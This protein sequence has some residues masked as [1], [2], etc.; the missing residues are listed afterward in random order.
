MEKGELV[1]C[2]TNVLIE[3]YKGNTN[4]ISSLKEIGQENI[5]ISI[6]TSGE[7]I[8][9]AF[10]K[11]ELRQIER[12][13]SNLKVL[14]I[15]NEI[16]VKFLDLMFQYALSHKLTIPDSII[17]ATAII[18]DIPLFT[19]NERDFRYIDSLKMWQI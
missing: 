8:F 14:S 12:D 7:L 13:I 4:I 5:A 11:R 3:L 6:I 17:A 15:D 9:G 16:S 18:C 19:L 2:D 10:N 1:L